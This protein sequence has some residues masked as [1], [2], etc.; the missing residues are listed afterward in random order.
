MILLIFK[1]PIT[2]YRDIIIVKSCEN[3][4][5]LNFFYVSQPASQVQNDKRNLFFYLKKVWFCNEAHVGGLSV[6]LMITS[7]HI[8]LKSKIE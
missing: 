1:S 6:T 5:T 3:W 4:V 8:K 2:L 7:P